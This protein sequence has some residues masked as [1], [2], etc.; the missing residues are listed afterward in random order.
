MNRRYG[1]IGLPRAVGCDTTGEQHFLAASA[2]IWQQ[3]RKFRS[4]FAT[5]HRNELQNAV[6]QN[7][8]PHGSIGVPAS[9]PEHRENHNHSQKTCSDPDENQHKH[10][11]RPSQH[12][13]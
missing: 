12:D 4:R 1:Q 13:R 6:R 2:R 8:G 3:R 9:V 10:D 5:T 7:S 11:R